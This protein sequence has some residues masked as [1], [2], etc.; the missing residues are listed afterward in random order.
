MIWCWTSRRMTW[1]FVW[2]TMNIIWKYTVNISCH[3]KSPLRYSPIT[4][5]EQDHYL[6]FIAIVLALGADLAHS[7]CSLNRWVT[8]Y[9]SRPFL[10]SRWSYRALHFLPHKTPPRWIVGS[11]LYRLGDWNWATGDVNAWLGNK[12]QQIQGPFSSSL[13]KLKRST[14][15]ISLF[16]EASW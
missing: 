2:L 1:R 14:W 4:L 5:W 7:R 12:I 3:H 15:A 8:T 6:F 9:R 10:P 16:T 11:F 13:E